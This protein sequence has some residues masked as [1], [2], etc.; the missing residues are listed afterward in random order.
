VYIGRAQGLKP[1]CIV[2]NNAGYAIERRIH[3]K[4]A[5]CG[6]QLRCRSSVMTACAQIQ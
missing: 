1:I 3:G 4:D 5:K 2:I 6:G